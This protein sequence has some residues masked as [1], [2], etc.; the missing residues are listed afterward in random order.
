MV[1][2]EEQLEVLD[3]MKAEDDAKREERLKRITVASPDYPYLSE[4]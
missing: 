3:R 2:T 4:Y 1:F